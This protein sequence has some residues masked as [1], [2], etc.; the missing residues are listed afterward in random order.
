M[1]KKKGISK[2]D[3]DALLS[4]KETN[5]VKIV[6]DKEKDEYDRE[7]KK[8]NILLKEIIKE[9]EKFIEN[10]LNENKKL[11]ETYDLIVSNIVEKD[12]IMDCLDE[13]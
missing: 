9:K 11:Q 2:D 8:E 7:L 3:N 13:I 12:S 1:S 4:K 5:L 10:L 6:Y